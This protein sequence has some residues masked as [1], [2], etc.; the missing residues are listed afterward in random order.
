MDSQS[1]RKLIYNFKNGISHNTVKDLV[2]NKLRSTFS[3]YDLSQMTFVCIP[4][5]T[6]VVH[7][8]RYKSFAEDVTQALGI[9][10]AY[11]YITITKEKPPSYLGGSDYAEYSFNSSFFQEKFVILFDDVVTSGGSIASMK[12]TLESIGAS[13]IC[14]LSI[15]RTYSDWNGNPR[16]PHPHT[17]RL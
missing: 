12:S 15:G 6:R 2:V 1:A 8:S 5:S 16:Q 13:V 11:D 3:S 14:A 10:N 9:L 7:E 4:A 17:G